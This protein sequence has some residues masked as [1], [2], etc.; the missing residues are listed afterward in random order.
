M[1]QAQ[2]DRID[3]ESFENPCVELYRGLEIYRDERSHYAYDGARLAARAPALDVARGQI[4]TYWES[5][6][7]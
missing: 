7:L 1:Q 2:F 3:R 4:D 6:Y 5:R